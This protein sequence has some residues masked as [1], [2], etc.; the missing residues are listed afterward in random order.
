[1]QKWFEFEKEMEL[2][3]SYDFHMLSE[4]AKSLFR[5]ITVLK[6]RCQLCNR[7]TRVSKRKKL[8]ENS[9]EEVNNESSH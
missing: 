9:E 1:M 6:H 8:T 5:V 4:Q 2:L 3:M 7:P